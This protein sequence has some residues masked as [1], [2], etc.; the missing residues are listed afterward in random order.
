MKKLVIEAYPPHHVVQQAVDLNKLVINTL[1][2]DI[3]LKG[4]INY[5]LNYHT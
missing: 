3:K 4:I 1:L 2:L 5:E